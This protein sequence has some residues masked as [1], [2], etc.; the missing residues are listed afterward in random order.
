MS[1]PVPINLVPHAAMLEGSREFLRMWAKPEGPMSCFIDPTKLGADPFLFGM[2]L[3]DA[4]RHGARAWAQATNMP[5][6]HIEERIWEGLDAE[7]AKPTDTPR[8]P[9]A[10]ADDDVITYTKPDGLN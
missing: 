2:A 9:D 7:R 8:A 5:V 6:G 4:V 1:K 10:P 3:V